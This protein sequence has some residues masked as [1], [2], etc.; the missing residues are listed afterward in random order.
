MNERQGTG[1]GTQTEALAEGGQK[2]EEPKMAEKQGTARRSQSGG[3]AAGARA[4]DANESFGA[5]NEAAMD[6]WRE[7]SE[8]SIKAAT[9]LNQELMNY[10]NRWCESA[11]EVQQSILQDG[12]LKGTMEKQGE[13]ARNATQQYF[14]GT[15]RIFKLASDAIEDMASPWSEFYAKT[16]PEALDPRRYS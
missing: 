6:A 9:T 15:S 16:M 2:T 11:F 13:F 5:V 14:E 10:T 7:Y 8:A 1:K 3:R 4:S 12:T